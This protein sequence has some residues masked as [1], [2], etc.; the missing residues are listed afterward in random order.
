MAGK[1]IDKENILKILSGIS[2]FKHVSPGML[3]HLADKCTVQ[4]FLSSSPIIRKGDAGDSIYIIVSG[5]VKVHDGEH[6]LA[7]L[8]DGNYFGEFSIIDNE[9]RSSSVTAYNDVILLSVDRND[10]YSVLNMFPEMTKDIMS[11]LSKR[12]RSQNQSYIAYLKNR[13]AELEFLVQKRTEE[14]NVKNKELADALHELELSLEKL[15]R[16]EKLAS[17]GQLTAGIAHELQNPLNFVNNFAL[18]TTGLISD[19]KSEQNAEEQKAILEDILANVERIHQHGTRASRIIK[20]MV[21]HSRLSKGEFEMTNLN[22]ICK[23]YLFLAYAG[24][25]SNIHGFECK[26]IENYDEKVPLIS[27]VPQDVARAL[28]NIINNA[29]Y[30]LNDK[31][32]NPETAPDY[33]PQL[34]VSTKLENEKIFI[35]IKDNA[36]GIPDEIK[37]KIFNPFF[38]TKPPGDGTGLGLSISHDIVR[39]LN[40]EI[41]LK[42]KVGEGTEFVISFPAQ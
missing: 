40:G 11:S 1:S 2:F 34:T 28:L 31:K 39:N 23:E 8:N 20:R 30:A 6:E 32:N 37:E 16:Q 3:M 41:V 21:D 24:I 17:L 35:S 13:E 14:L 22:S 36:I 19:Y 26:L 12:M 15:V 27:T 33:S 4:N 5:T 18:L 9:P 38:T 42:S 10:F 29:F 25:K 7:L